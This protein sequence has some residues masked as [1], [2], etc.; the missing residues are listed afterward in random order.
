MS[1]HRKVSLIR[2][3]RTVLACHFTGHDW[4]HNGPGSWSVHC[5]RPGC[6]ETFHVPPLFTDWD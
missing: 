2:L 3:C 6:D 4:Q 1:K 5:V